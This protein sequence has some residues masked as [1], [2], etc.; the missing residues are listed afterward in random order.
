MNSTEYQI[1]QNK[2][3]TRLIMQYIPPRYSHVTF[4]KNSFHDIVIGKVQTSNA[5]I[6]YY[7]SIGK[8]EW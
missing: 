7:Q 6:A 5:K 1:S 4:V 8:I 2:Y 3:L